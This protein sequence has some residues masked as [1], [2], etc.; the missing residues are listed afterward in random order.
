MKGEAIQHGSNKIYF[1]ATRRFRGFVELQIKFGDQN[2]FIEP[3][4]IAVEGVPTVCVYA[5][6]DRADGTRYPATWRAGK[7]V[8]GYQV[9]FTGSG[10]GP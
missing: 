2:Q 1:P 3:L 8:A 10:G 9:V 4:L 7:D 6:L 5:A